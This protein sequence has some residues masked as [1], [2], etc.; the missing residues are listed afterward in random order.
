MLDRDPA[1]IAREGLNQIEDADSLEALGAVHASLFGKKGL[2]STAMRSL[3]EQPPAE[4]Q[5]LGA[6]LN[7]CKT[8]LETALEQRRAVLLDQLESQNLQREPLDLSLS[9]PGQ[10]PGLLHPIPHLFE[11]LQA[12]FLE[13]G[14]FSAYGPDIESDFYNFTALNMPPDHPARQMQ[15]SFYLNQTDEAGADEAGGMPY[16]LR[17][18]TS[19]VQ[20]RTMLSRPPPFRMIAPGRTYRRDSDQTHTPMFHQL[21]G[22][23]LGDSVHFG[24]LKG[25]LTDFCE[26]FFEG[27]PVDLRFRPSYFPFTEPSAEVDIRCRRHG[28]HVEIGTGTEWLEI[29]G[30]GMVHENVLTACRLDPTRVQGFAF[31]MGIERLAMLKYGMPDLRAF[32]T[33]SLPWTRHYGFSPIP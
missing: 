33:G 30:C 21:E 7:R 2:V 28:T 24:H 8:D 3:R 15:D 13:M 6:G 9:G 16:V 5:Q 22:L 11:E 4:R 12:I 14:F 10:T 17:T 1:S 23:V 20:V 29:L 18:H 26:A 31:G 19:P 25:C 32:F 27:A